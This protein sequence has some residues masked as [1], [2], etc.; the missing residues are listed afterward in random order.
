MRITTKVFYLLMLL[1]LL[2][3]RAFGQT[4]TGQITGTV[5]DPTGA[6]IPTA[7]VTATDLA[8][9]TA[10]TV[11]TGDGIYAFPNLLPGRYEVEAAAPSF[12]TTKEVVTVTVGSKI[13]LNLRLELGATTETVEVVETAT[14]INTETQ[15]LGTTISGDEVLDLPTITRNPYDL[16]KTVGNTTDSDGAS[17][18]RGVKVSMN[19]LRSTDVGILLDGVPNKN[20]FDTL[21]AMDIP[22]D[23]VGEVSVLTN[24]FTAEYGRALAGFVNVDT[25]RGTN[26]IHGTVYEFNRA[27]AFAS[28]TFDNNA[29]GVAKPHFTRNQFGFSAG[30]P[31]M[32]DKLF[33]FANPE[34]LR[35]RSGASQQATIVTPQLL[36]ASA[37][38]TQT[39]FSTYGI[40]KPDI[41]PIRT[42]RYDQ[43]CPTS[44][45]SC[46]LIPG[47]TPSYQL[48]S[49]NV[50]ADSGGGDPQNTLLLVGRFDYVLSD[51]TQFYFRYARYDANFAAGDVTNSPYVG[52][53]TAESD[54]KNSYVLSATHMFSP[55]L[56]SQTK[57]S[58]NRVFILQ[59]LSTAPIGPTLY[60]T[61]GSTN[62]IG[63][64][65]FVYPG[66]SPFSPGNAV[67]FGGPQ[68]YIQF[69]E[70]VSKLK[71]KHNL[72]FG[73]LYTYLQDNRTFGAYEEAVAALGT[74]TPSAVN[75][76]LTGTL[77]DFQAAVYPQGKFP[78]IN[79]A[80]GPIVTPAC[81]LTLPVTPP[82]FSRSNAFDEAA[83]YVQDSWKVKPRLTLNL[84]LRWEYFGP[85]A[86][87]NPNLDS[88]FYL[89]AGS[90]IE[91]QSGTGQVL[92]ATD[93][94]N[95]VGGLWEKDWHDFGPRV[96]FAW[97]VFGNGKTSLRGG[98]GLGWNPNFG[99][100]S[101][102]VIQNPP[103]Y[104]VIALTAGS[105]V[106]TIAITTDNSGPLAGSTG[107]K[108]IPRV[109]LRAVDPNIKTEYA[110]LWSAALEHQFGTDLIA[111]IEYTGSKGVNLYSI[112]RLNIPGS[113]VVYGGTGSGSGSSTD[114]INNQYSYIN[115][116]TNGGFS[117][118][119]A[120][121]VRTEMRNFRR[122]G[123]TLR[124]NYSWSHAIDNI[125]NTFS[126]TTTG[127]GNLGVLDP[128]NPG[129]DKGDAEYD[130]RNRVT[131]AAVWEEPYKGANRVTDAILGGWSIIP[132][133]NARTGIPFTAWD[134][135]NKRFVVCPR[136][137]YDTPFQPVYT[138][139]PTGS[140]NE[141]T[142]MSLGKPD[143][144][145]KNPN[146]DVALGG[147]SDFGPFPSTMTGR[148]A[149]RAPGFWNMDF[150][151]HKNFNVSER[152][153]LQLRAEAFNVFNHSNLY[154]VYSNTDFHSDGGNITATRGVRNDNSAKLPTTENRNLQL[155][156]KLLF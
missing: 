95:P 40:L 56:V 152:F 142:Y 128:L 42:F 59:G 101:F 49:Y 99:N 112:N 149:F 146:V 16:V 29:K 39:F 135:T 52:Y 107:T 91:L 108:A 5:L 63:S 57:V 28:N 109:T 34:W 26:A 94:N 150:A 69:N 9:R 89:G 124:F 123:V 51:K 46:T 24:T 139:T 131:V 13:G 47:S 145:Y 104:S 54:L 17:R 68:N 18:D 87:R 120:L 44:N 73:G 35:V 153:K 30:G 156:L 80:S 96:G 126:E 70:D 64:G 75:G 86:S 97:D 37:P 105:D 148:D 140:P 3:T 84:G 117:N 53:D 48:V 88:N 22:L 90:N 127:A 134:C 144:S 11:M 38:A 136:V 79:G 103:N 78:C 114:R 129:L 20:N 8:T 61:L 27:S 132:N 19:G 31:I 32:K 147:A 82:N 62:S 50:P 113:T 41:I 115:F 119:N 15:T 21:V 65:Q 151:V 85:Q 130:V 83:L 155:A 93:R 55:T 100:V 121:N 106:P 4:E 10:R 25:K 66:Y 14:Q 133:F 23:S 1:S 111:A 154:L 67:P 45:A 12:K 110:H 60:T 141:F 81:T 76:F 71:G 116:R 102:N 7:T 118:Y 98:Y 36:A 33:V 6:F 137:M 143:T 72:R 125:S 2:T 43:V 77:H 74:D 92:V 58:Y 122:Q 138:Q